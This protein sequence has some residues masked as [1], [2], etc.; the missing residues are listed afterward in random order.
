MTRDAFMI[1][2]AALYASCFAAGAP[3]HA[4]DITNR[5]SAGGFERTYTVFVPDRLQKERG[6]FPTVM[7]LHGGLGTGSIIRRQIHMDAVATREGFVTVYPDGLGSGWNDGRGD[8][9]RGRYGAADDGAFLRMVVNTL[10]RDEIAVHSRVF[11]TGVSNGGMMSLRMGCEAADLFAAIAPIIANL[12][13]DIVPG[14]K[15]SRPVPLLLI[16]GMD[17]P[18]VPWSGGGAGFRGHRGEVISTAATIDFWRQVNGCSPEPFSLTLKLPASGSGT[19]LDA[20][21]FNQCR[22]GAPV[23]L[24]GIKGGG[25]RIPGREEHAHPFIDRL[26][27]PQ[28]HDFETAEEVWHFFVSHSSR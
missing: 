5:I 9:A 3:S 22:S 26:V 18:L 24:V 13:A 17:D 8:S 16:N 14:C 27:G 12:P 21:L 6:P 20:R 2:A 25:H 4:R 28:N 19:G 1:L 10:I 7:V 15:P 23:A 11:L